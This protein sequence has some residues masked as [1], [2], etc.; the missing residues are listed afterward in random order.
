LARTQE[1][2]I[3]WFQPIAQPVGAEPSV[4]T[5]LLSRSASSNSTSPPGRYRGG[6][7]IGDRWRCTRLR[8]SHSFSQFV[9]HQADFREGGSTADELAF[10]GATFAPDTS[11]RSCASDLRSNIGGPPLVH[12]WFDLS[13]LTV[14]AWRSDGVSPGPVP[15]L[16]HVF[17][18]LL[19]IGDRSLDLLSALGDQ[20]RRLGLQTGDPPHGLGRKVI[21]AHSIQN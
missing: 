3:S 17:E 2:A 15:D 8:W 19:R 5:V 13:A 11:R 10:G 16:G 6:R 21:A 18:M 1:Q 20:T 12:R 7:A 9:L 14:Q 4:T